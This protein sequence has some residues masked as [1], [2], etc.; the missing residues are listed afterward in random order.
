MVTVIQ[1]PKVMSPKTSTQDKL[2]LYKAPFNRTAKPYEAIV[3]SKADCTI[4]EDIAL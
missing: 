1:L 4:F 3:Y 2:R